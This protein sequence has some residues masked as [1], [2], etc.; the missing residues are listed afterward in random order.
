MGKDKVPP[1][2]YTPPAPQYPAGPPAPAPLYPTGQYPSAQ[3]SSFPAAS[4]APYPT[5]SPAPQTTVVMATP[6]PAPQMVMVAPTHQ[7]ALPDHVKISKGK[8]GSKATRTT[9]G[10]CRQNMETR[11]IYERGCFAWTMCILMCCI[12]LFFGPCLIPLFMKKCKDAHHYCT[13]CNKK[14]CVHKRCC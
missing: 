14:L 9:C 8:L 6:Q 2:A 1:P 13:M 10:N 4:H 12:G 11:V 7:Q 5:A 3:Y